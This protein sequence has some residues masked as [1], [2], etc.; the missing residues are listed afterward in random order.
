[1][2]T[3]PSSGKQTNKSKDKR[4]TAEHRHSEDHEQ[5]NLDDAVAYF[6][7]ED[8]STKVRN[9]LPLS[10][11]LETIENQAKDNG[12]GTEHIE[13]LVEVAAS[14]RFPDSVNIR[15]IKSLIPNDKVTAE[16]FL[17]AVSWMCT[18]KPSS[19]VQSMLIRWMIIV[20]DL[21]EEQQKVQTLYGMIFFFT[22]N[23]TMCPHVCQLLYLMTRKEDVRMFRIRHLLNLQLKMVNYCE[24]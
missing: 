13:A 14:S 5:R 18:N 17:T 8:S 24:L 4:S 3:R 22:E 12:L 7:N 21:V 23:E 15:L 11:S 1:M 19:N 2:S 10:L 20:Y 9:N 16:S 6:T